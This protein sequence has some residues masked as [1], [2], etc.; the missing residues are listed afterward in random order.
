MRLNK[1]TA[2]WFENQLLKRLNIWETFCVICKRTIINHEPKDEH[3]FC[4]G[5]GTTWAEWNSKGGCSC[6][7][8]IPLDNLEY[9]ESLVDKN[10]NK[11]QSI[12]K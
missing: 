1:Q 11:S 5:L 6:C 7:Q 10:Q 8:Y 12:I 3:P 4:K 9:L 2:I